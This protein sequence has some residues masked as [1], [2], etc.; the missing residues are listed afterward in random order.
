VEALSLHFLYFNYK[1]LAIKWKRHDAKPFSRYFKRSGGLIQIVFP[2]GA[3]EKAQ[4]S[5]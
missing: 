1:Y 5:C 2:S 3:F 4:G